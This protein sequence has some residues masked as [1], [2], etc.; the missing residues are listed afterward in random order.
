LIEQTDTSVKFVIHGKPQTL[1]RHQFNPLRKEFYNPSYRLQHEFNAVT[2]ELLGLS[3]QPI[4][5]KKV[6]KKR[7][8]AEKMKK[9]TNQ[10]V[11]EES[12]EDEDVEE[13]TLAAA[14]AEQS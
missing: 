8:A 9:S 10:K 14:G 2:R 11:G 3:K 1:K 13:K 5:F 4:G 12:S 6:Q 7:I